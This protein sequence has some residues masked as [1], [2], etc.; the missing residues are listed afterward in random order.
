MKAYTTAFAAK[1]TGSG[2]QTITGVVDEHGTAFTPVLFLFHG[3]ST[4]NT[5]VAKYDRAHGFDDGTTAFGE[6]MAEN[7]ASGGKISSYFSSG[8]SSIVNGTAA[9]INGGTNTRFAH[10]SAV[11]SG[12]FTLTYDT[13]TLTG[14]VIFVTVLGGT[15]LEQAIG[16][17][18]A[19]SSTA[20]TTGIQSNVVLLKAQTLT[21]GQANGNPNAGSNPLG[22]GWQIA[23][24]SPTFT[25]GNQGT[26]AAEPLSQSTNRRYQSDAHAIATSTG[27]SARSVSAFGATS[28]TLSGSGSYG[29]AALGGIQAAAGTL[30]QP[31]AAGFQSIDTGINPKVIFFQSA[32]CT[33]NGEQTTSAVI[34]IAASD[35]TRQIGYWAGEVTPDNTLPLNCASYLS[36]STVLRFGTPAGTGTTFTSVG[37]V[38]SIN[39]TTGSVLLNW[40]LC[41]GTQRQVYWLALGDALGPPTPP[42]GT[43]RY[44][45]CLRRFPLPW[46]PGNVWQFLA[47]LEVICQQGV[48]L[49]TGQGSAPI[50]MARISRDGGSTFGPELQMSLGAQGE[51]GFRS[52]LNRLG[53]GRNFVIELACTDPVF[54]SFI[55][56]NA[57]LSD[58]TS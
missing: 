40:S 26:T 5:L 27:S 7:E 6:C 18:N 51:Y 54:L 30:T 15:D 4:L 42:T 20:I 31:A 24:A 17:T 11:A 46:R 28:F 56:A 47:R 50:I 8:V 1:G 12:Q 58:G 44:M 22:F 16:W 48:G 36:D 38:S 29:Y 57:D 23:G 53:R 52:Y 41:D 2:T 9:A 55:A 45:R 37:A 34:A 21:P 3:S 14:D 32:D 10:V 19:N 43:T 39:R 13:N 49:S 33:A 35:G 25:P